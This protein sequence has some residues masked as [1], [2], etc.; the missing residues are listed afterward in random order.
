MAPDNAGTIASFMSGRLTLKLNDGTMVSG[1]VSPATEV[2]CEAAMSPRPTTAAGED[3]GR[4][5]SGG[6]HRSG[7][8]R[9][10]GG[11]DDN[12]GRDEISASCG[13]SALVAGAIVHEAELRVSSSGS[14]F[15]RVEVVR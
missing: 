1:A 12:G 2:E 10:H 14:T 8:S 11:G 3:G 15:T 4:D 5:D 7:S 9:D 6:E 13:V